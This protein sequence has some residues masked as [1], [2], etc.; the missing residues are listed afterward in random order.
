MKSGRVN[1]CPGELFLKL[2]ARIG[3]WHQNHS[4][5]TE[6]A[7]IIQ[8]HA[9]RRNSVKQ[10]ILIGID[11]LFVCLPCLIFAIDILKRKQTDLIFTNN[12]QQTSIAKNLTNRTLFWFCFVFE[13][14]QFSI[15]SITHDFFTLF[16]LATALELPLWQ[17]R[18]PK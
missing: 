5:K 8:K 6:I 1:F 18:G 7:Q 13:G 15:V 10:A 3:E 16:I 2:L 9:K 14:G 11:F 4:E 12:L 17:L